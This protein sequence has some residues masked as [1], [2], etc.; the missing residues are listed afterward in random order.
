MLDGARRSS[1]I[2]RDAVARVADYSAVARQEFRKRWLGGVGATSALLAQ[3][4]AGGLELQDQ[5]LKLNVTLAS[6]LKQ[7]FVA[8]A[9]AQGESGPTA[10]G[11]ANMDAEAMA[12]ALRHYDGYQKYVAGSAGLMPPAYRKGL[13]RALQDSAARAMWSALSGRRAEPSVALNGG[14]IDEGNA[15]DA[16]RP[17]RPPRYWRRWTN[18]PNPLSATACC[19]RWTGARCNPCVTRNAACKG[20]LCTSRCKA[21]SAGGTARATPGPAPSAPAARGNCSNT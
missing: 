14:S 12:A 10:S 21:A 9:R 2:G 1:L 18:W 13:E 17:R 8:S 19:A 3:G 20:W 15:F 16:H 4:P 7:D 11:L 6:L 5:V